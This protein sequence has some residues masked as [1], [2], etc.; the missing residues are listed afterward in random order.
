MI[1]GCRKIRSKIVAICSRLTGPTRD[2]QLA[3]VNDLLAN[4]LPANKFY[5]GKLAGCRLPLASLDELADLPYTFKDELL[6]APGSGGFA[7]NSDIRSRALRALSPDVGHARPPAGRARHGRR[8]AMVDGVLELRA[9][10][11][12]RNA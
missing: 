5:A 10:C 9:G 3:A 8:L 4:M 7:A 6:P 11:G 1:L 2:Y 12:R